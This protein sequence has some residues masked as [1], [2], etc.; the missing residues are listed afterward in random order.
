MVE[1]EKIT[2]EPCKVAALNSISE[3][4]LITLRARA[5][6]SQKK[7]PVLKDDMGV[8]C[9]KRL[10]GLVPQEI[11]ERIFK[12]KLPSTLT[13]HLALRARKYD[14]YARIF[15]E[16]HPDGLVVS[17][18]CGFDT[19]YWRMFQKPW[20]YVEVDLPEVIEAKRVILDDSAQYL[21]IAG[22]VTE[23]AWIQKIRSIQNDN[24]FFIAEGLFM[25]LPKV[26]AIRIF[27]R[28]STSFTKSQIAV[29]VVSERLTRGLGKKLLKSKM[30]RSFGMKDDASFSFGIRDAREIETY[31]NNIRVVE[32]WSYFE[33]RDIEPKF[34]RLFRNLKSMTRSQWTI[35]ATID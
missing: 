33:D 21:M 25:Y 7:N 24:V 14:S 32:E 20:K 13:R 16:G 5:I 10:R 17:L 27:N 34:F 15:M 1:S 2:T 29:E 30:Q 6:E 4:A 3:T 11:E 28:I 9:L 8:E 12:R 18:G 31:G 26:E 22:S 23:E 19:R 35:R